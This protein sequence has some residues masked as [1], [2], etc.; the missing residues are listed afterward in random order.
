V[1]NLVVISSIFILM[2]QVY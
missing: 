2:K 1:I